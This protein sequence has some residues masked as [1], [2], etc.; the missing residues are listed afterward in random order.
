MHDPHE[1]VRM[2]VRSLLS[3]QQGKLRDDAT[4]LCFDWHHPA[5]RPLVQGR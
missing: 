2:L 1:A 3:Y 4:L 5:A